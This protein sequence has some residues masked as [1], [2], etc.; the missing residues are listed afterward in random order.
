V[1]RQILITVAMIL[2]PYVV[3]GVI[4]MIAQR[5]V[6]KGQVIEVRPESKMPILALGLVGCLLAVI[7][8]VAIAILDNNPESPRYVPPVERST[9]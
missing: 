5:R 4:Q 1:L 7:A 3:Y 8:L 9:R 6:A 2:L